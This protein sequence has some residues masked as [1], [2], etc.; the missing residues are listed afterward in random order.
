MERIVRSNPDTQPRKRHF[1]HLLVDLLRVPG[2]HGLFPVEPDVPPDEI[3]E[4][5]S[6]GFDPEV[7]QGY[8]NLLEGKGSD[9]KRSAVFLRGA[10]NELIDQVNQLE[11]ER[12]VEV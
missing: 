1:G 6:V 12:G 10:F 4:I 8:I 2:N 9:G 11:A 3:R 5:E 7:V